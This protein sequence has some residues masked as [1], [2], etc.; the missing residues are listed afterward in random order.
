MI[1]S[2]SS[3]ARSTLAAGISNASALGM[4]SDINMDNADH[5]YDMVLLNNLLLEGRF[6]IDDSSL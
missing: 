2:N 6:H 3:N 5:M 4:Q 1:S